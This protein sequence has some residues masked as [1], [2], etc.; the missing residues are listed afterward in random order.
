ML[1]HLIMPF[2]QSIAVLLWPFFITNTPKCCMNLTEEDRIAF[3]GQHSQLPKPDGFTQQPMNFVTPISDETK[4]NC[5]T[6]LDSF[7]GP[8]PAS[9]RFQYVKRE[10]AWYISSRE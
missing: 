6:M 5:C 9:R 3:S 8:R 1:A 7:P 2:L 4:V 10:R